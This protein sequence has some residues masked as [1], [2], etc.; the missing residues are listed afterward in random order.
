M[1]ANME[2]IYVHMQIGKHICAHANQVC[3]IQHMIPEQE[4]WQL[5]SL[6]CEVTLVLSVQNAFYIDGTFFSDK[7]KR[8]NTQVFCT[9]DATFFLKKAQAWSGV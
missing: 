7:T 8:R 3:I 5:D 9:D 2:H 1:T 4:A 6:E